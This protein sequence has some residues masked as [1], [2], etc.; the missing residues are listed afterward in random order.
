VDSFLFMAQI[1]RV[2]MIAV[3]PEMGKV[4]HGT[5]RQ[6]TLSIPPRGRRF[7]SRKLCRTLATVK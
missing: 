2:E 4:H 6:Y 1:P 3:I 7:K 5:G